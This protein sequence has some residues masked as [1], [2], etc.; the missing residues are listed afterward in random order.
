M[1]WLVKQSCIKCVWI[2]LLVYGRDVV[3]FVCSTDLCVA[4]DV[5]T[6]YFAQSV[7][8]PVTSTVTSTVTIPVSSP[9]QYSPHITK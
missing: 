6:L 4:F 1:Y 2:A 5:Y 3:V 7:T 8:S 9:L